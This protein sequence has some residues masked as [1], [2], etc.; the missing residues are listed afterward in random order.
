VTTPFKIPEGFKSW[1][2]AKQLEFYNS[3][4]AQE[5]IKERDEA[6]E[7]NPLAFYKPLPAQKLFHQCD[8]RFRLATGGNRSG[9]TEAGVVEDLYWIL[10]KSPYR[11]IPKGPL[12][13]VVS[14]LSLGLFETTLLEKFKEYLIKGVIKVRFSKA[15]GGGTI[16]GPNGMIYIKSNE[17]GWQSFQGMALDFGHL[18][19]EHSY[20]VFK[21]MRKRLKKGRKINIW[22]TMT[23]E[24][25]KPDHW[26]YDTLCLP[27]RDPAK[28]ADYSH[29][30]FDLEDN[31]ISRGG[32]LDDTEIDALIADTPVEERPAVIHGKY[33]KR[34]GLVYPAFSQKVHVLE[35]R[36]LKS[37]LDAT[38]KGVYTAF[39]YLD[40]GVRNPTAMGLILE[41]K[42][43][44]CHLIDEIYRPAR[45]VLDIK[46]EFHT[47]WG[48]F[49][50]S[51]VVADPSI[52]HNHESQDPERTIAGQLSTDDYANRSP[53][54]PII[55]GNNS[56][57]NGLMAMRELLRVDPKAGPK[58]RVQPR[59]HHWIREIE[60]YVGEE[61][62]SRQG[63]RNKKEVPKKQND[64]HMDGTRYFAMSSHGHDGWSYDD[65]APKYETDG[66]GFMRIA[67]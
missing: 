49:K 34:G 29:F 6:R 25:D 60:N 32:Y 4:A 22:T 27:S 12:V 44:N 7:A 45:D 40:W 17:A 14:A 43:G 42:D 2:R 48:G 38:R 57:D 20:E 61:W 62:M 5:A 66:A 41:D 13:G 55:K 21:Q 9:K 31:R 54:L 26:T 19:E 39:G 36:S 28:K 50:V 58:L 33:V 51:F 15:Q 46:R 65:Q 24:P 3:P 1:P 53:G 63:D 11:K 8:T 52:W 59:C 23:A 37:Y 30:E 18:D 64:H 10:G 16:E 67:I 47:R 56:M 35:E